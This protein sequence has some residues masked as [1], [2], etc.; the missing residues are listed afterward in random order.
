MNAPTPPT[1]ETRQPPPPKAPLRLHIGGHEV[2]DGWK[3][4]NIQKGDGVDFVGTAADLSQFVDGSVLE[5]YGSHVYEHL[6]YQTELPGA[7]REAYRVLKP[8]GLFRAG[9][10]DLE[11]LCQLFL[12][13]RLSIDDRFHVQRMMFGGQIDPFDFHKVGLSFE[14]FTEF[15]NGAR[16][17]NI[18]RVE[19]FN[20][21]DDT[22]KLRYAGR[23]ISLNIV[24]VK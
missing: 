6:D 14:I 1:G 20:L 23:R 22:S 15:L 9:V 8:G 13:K 4:L 3:I 16:F 21:F 17:K 18:H 10:P 12:D 7:L 19:D 5:I 24:A 2:R 11:V